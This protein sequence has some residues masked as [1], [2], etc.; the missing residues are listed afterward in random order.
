M[1]DEDGQLQ[2]SNSDNT[3]NENNPLFGSNGPSTPPHEELQEVVISPMPEYSYDP[4]K[5]VGPHGTPPNTSP[6]WNLPGTCT[7]DV[8]QGQLRSGA[9]M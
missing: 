9:D 6:P 2:G 4:T 7:S 1:L 8:Q 3:N 5:D